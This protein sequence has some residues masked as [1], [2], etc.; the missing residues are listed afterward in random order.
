MKKY[1]TSQTNPQWIPDN[2][3]ANQ[4]P[5]WGNLLHFEEENGKFQF[6]VENFPNNDVL[7]TELDMAW[8]P[9]F[10][11]G[12]ISVIND[13]TRTKYIFNKFDANVFSK[14]MLLECISNEYNVVYWVGNHIGPSVVSKKPVAVVSQTTTKPTSVVQPVISSFRNDFK[15]LENARQNNRMLLATALKNH[16][17]DSH[18]FEL[19]RDSLSRYA[20]KHNKKYPKRSNIRDWFVAE[21]IN[22]YLNSNGT[23]QL[24]QVRPKKAAKTKTTR[25]SVTK[26]PI[27]G[28]L[29]YKVMNHY[30]TSYTHLL[31]DKEYNYSKS[32]GGKCTWEDPNYANYLKELDLLS[33]IENVNRPVRDHIKKNMRNVWIE[34]E[35]KRRRDCASFSNKTT[36]GKL[37]Y[38]KYCNEYIKNLVSSN[39]IP[40]SVVRDWKYWVFIK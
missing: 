34:Y 5:Y 17:I 28:T 3:P 12:A 39:K 14:E 38:A 4:I 11:S 19:F 27:P 35:F 7:C 29:R 2:L 6:V 33:K 37:K 40:S 1:N 32:H 9:Y 23:Y 31:Y 22:K 36:E 18:K 16:V 20:D 21:E 13:A 8:R 10:A 24:Y 26:N 30:G 15:T 25:S